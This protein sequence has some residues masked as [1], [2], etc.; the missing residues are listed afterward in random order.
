MGRLEGSNLNKRV[1]ELS[2]KINQF[3]NTPLPPEFIILD[4]VDVINILKIS[5]RKLF[6][7]RQKR[8]IEFHPTSLTGIKDKR[9]RNAIAEKAKGRRASKIYYTL[10]GVL[11]YIQRYTV[12]PLYSNLNIAS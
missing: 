2:E 8:E 1:L 11:N 9:L 10:R 12:T 3:S 4:D 6:E 7:I 5:K